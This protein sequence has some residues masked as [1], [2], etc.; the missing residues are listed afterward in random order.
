MLSGGDALE[1]VGG[2]KDGNTVVVAEHVQIG[3][4]RDD[5]I[6][7]RG[8]RAGKDGR[9]IGIAQRRL[10]NGR[11]LDGFGDLPVARDDLG[12]R[13]VLLSELLGELGSPEDAGEF[14]QE[15]FGGEEL[16]RAF[17][18][19]LDQPFGGAAPEKGGGDDVGIKDDAHGPREAP[20]APPSVRIRVPLR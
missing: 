4:A 2:R 8:E 6:C 18:G 19:E 15:R 5:C 10:L 14:V 1:A 17:A 20:R 9:V 16:E 3:V 11:G 12:G 13:D 7:P